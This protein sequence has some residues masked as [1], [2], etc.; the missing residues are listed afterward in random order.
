MNEYKERMPT[1]IEL[2]LEQSQQCVSNDVL[3]RIEGVEELKRNVWIKGEN[4][5][6]LHYTFRQK[7]GGS[8][9]QP[10]ISKTKSAR[11]ESRA[12]KSSVINLIKTQSMYNT[13]CSPYNNIWYK[14]VLRIFLEIWPEHPSDTK[15][16]TLKMEILLKPMSNKL[17]VESYQIKIDITAPTLT[18]PEEKRVMDLIDIAKFCATLEKVLSEVKLK[19]FETEFLKK[20]QLLV[21]L[22]LK[23]IKAYDQE[24]EKHLKHREQMRR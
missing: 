18:F 22:D 20:A 16:F 21:N 4:K 1:K 10:P 2:T 19:I 5:A 15:V 8:Q 6:A 3:V 17:L 13:C 7:P 11:I 23:I 14:R 24:I 12:N 9:L